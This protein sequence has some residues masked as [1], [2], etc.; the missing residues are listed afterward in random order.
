MEDEEWEEVLDACMKVS[1]KLSDRLTQL[2]ILHKSYLTP[3]RMAK[4]RANYSPLC[5]SCGDTFFILF[6]HAL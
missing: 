3:L 2:Y 6:G 1:P 4:Y 5:P